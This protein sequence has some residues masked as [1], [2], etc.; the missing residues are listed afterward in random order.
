MD[1]QLILQVLLVLHVLH[2]LQQDG[3]LGSAAE[4]LR[5]GNGIRLE[6]AGLR[7]ERAGLRLERSGLRLEHAGLRLERAGLILEGIDD[8]RAYYVV[9]PILDCDWLYLIILR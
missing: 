6:R 7:L 4:R 3:P 5:T 2:A 8:L 1:L 9:V